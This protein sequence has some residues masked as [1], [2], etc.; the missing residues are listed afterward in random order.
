MTSLDLGRL[1][2]FTLSSWILLYELGGFGA[3]RD[4]ILALRARFRVRK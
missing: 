4:L 1:V 3:L 2:L